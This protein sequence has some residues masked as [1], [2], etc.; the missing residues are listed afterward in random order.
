MCIAIHLTVKCGYFVIYRDNFGFCVD[1]SKCCCSSS[2]KSTKTDTKKN[3]VKSFYC[4]GF[5]SFHFWHLDKDSGSM[6]TMRHQIA[7]LYHT[8]FFHWLNCSHSCTTKDFSDIDSTALIDFY[9]P[10]DWINTHFQ[11][12]F[13]MHLSKFKWQWC[14]NHQNQTNSSRVQPGLDFRLSRKF[15]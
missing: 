13:P 10:R 4:L 2:H 1:F 6:T 5:I 15:Y 14:S 7:F 12:C 3:L 8:D 11:L 9:P